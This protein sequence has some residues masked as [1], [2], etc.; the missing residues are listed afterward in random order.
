VFPKSFF[1]RPDRKYR[2]G[3]ILGAVGLAIAGI[4][5]GFSILGSL[6]DLPFIFLGPGD[7]FVGAYGILAFVIPAYLIAAALILADP[8]YRPDR[9]FI[10]SAA[11]FPFLTLAIGLA[12][13]RD[14]N[15][16]AERFRF[17]VLLG[18]AGFSFC[19]LLFTF[20]EI[21]TIRTLA[22]LLFPAKPKSPDAETGGPAR[23]NNLT[24]GRN[25]TLTLT[26]TLPQLGVVSSLVS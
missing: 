7:F 24:V 11:I 21:A 25:G 2:L 9:I 19:I 8:K 18:K 6:L 12:I 17:M 14:F 3:S 4:L 13:F 1:P 5:M 20:L 22:I 15:S 16:H 10:L 23:G 26:L